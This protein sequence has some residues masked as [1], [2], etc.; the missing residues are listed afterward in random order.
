MENKIKSHLEELD[1]LGY[2]VIEDVLSQE[3]LKLAQEKILQVYD[4]QKQ[5]TEGVVDITKTVENNIA[6]M[7][8]SYDEYFYNLLNN[9]KI[10]PYIKEVLGDY[11]ILQTQNGVIV[12]PN[13]TH[14][15]NKWHRDLS[16]MNFVSD[17]PL[18]INA[19][20]CITDF[21]FKTG[22]TQLLPF[23]HKINY[24]PTPEYKEKHGISVEAKA[25]SVFLFN[26]MMFHRTGLNVSD[27]VRIGINHLYCRYILKQQIDIPALLNFETPEDPFMS[28]LLGFDSHV[29]TNVLNYR[30]AR[31]KSA[32]KKKK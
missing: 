18:A 15:Q 26:T 12:Q 17:P 5:E 11:F 16:Y 32:D 1:I 29:P 22:A 10:I 30:L 14:S 13:I 3:E 24:E 9:N 25:G 23:T 27:Q 19:F 2:T 21:N 8:F 7:P 28:M 4:I 6:R 20:F 31:K